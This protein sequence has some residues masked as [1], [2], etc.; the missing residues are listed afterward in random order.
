MIYHDTP[1]RED[2]SALFDVTNRSSVL[3]A[4]LKPF[5]EHDLERKDPS[6]HY[7][8]HRAQTTREVGEVEPDQNNRC[9]ARVAMLFLVLKTLG[10]DAS[11]DQLARNMPMGSR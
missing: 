10:D 6:N 2:I 11:D 9:L 7:L 1:T 4:I 3:Y 5:V 8:R